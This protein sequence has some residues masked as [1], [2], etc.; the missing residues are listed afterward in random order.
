MSY[1][2]RPASPDQY[3]D[4]DLDDSPEEGEEGQKKSPSLKASAGNQNKKKAKTSTSSSSPVEEKGKNEWEIGSK[5]KVT[6]SKFRNQ[7]KIDIR[8]YYEK[9]GQ[10]LPG[11]KGIS[12]SVEQ[13][14]SLQ[15]IASEVNAALGQ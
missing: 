14:Q 6:L 10:L 12:L 8:E 7:Q 9:D 5:R 11:R 1:K 2:K 4:D 13:W 15:K 3:S